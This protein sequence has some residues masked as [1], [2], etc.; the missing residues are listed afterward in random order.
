MPL[1]I[2]VVGVLLIIIVPL[3]WAIGAYN[4]LVK[5]RKQ[6]KDTFTQIDVQL[7]RL[8]DLISNLV[9]TAEGDLSYE[10]ETL[11]AVIDARNH[12]QRA[13]KLAAADPSNM[14]A[15]KNMMGAESSLSGD[16]EKLMMVV[17]ANPDLKTNQTMAQ[18]TEELTTIHN[19][20]SVARQQYN[21]TVMQYNT[22]RE[23]FP[24]V[25][26][27]NMFMF[28]EAPLFEITDETEKETSEV[29]FGD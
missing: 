3:C 1:I 28:S 8:H 12:A 29:S 26:I 21:D 16:L 20:I 17:A 25:V 10:H 15:M 18:L 14:L 13:E 2:I 7:K 23:V 22:Q 5:L 11:E 9:E 24:S 4:R 19:E 6:F 27:A